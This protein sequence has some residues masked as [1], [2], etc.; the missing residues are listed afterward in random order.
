NILDSEQR[1]WQGASAKYR[2]LT[3]VLRKR[4][5]HLHEQFP[6]YESR[7]MIRYNDYTYIEDNGCIYQQKTGEQSCEVL[8]SPED[9]GLGEYQI[10]KIRVSTNQA[11]LAVT[12]KTFEIEE[13]TC[14]VIKLGS[15]PR[16]THRIQNVF[17]CEWVAESIL[18][19]TRQMNLQ[20]RQVYGMDFNQSNC[21]A[22]LVYNENDYRFFVDLYST[23][24]GRY[25]TINS[26]SKDTSEVWLLDKTS[27]WE[28]PVLVQGRVPGVTYFIEHRDG[29]LY[30]LSND[31]EDTEYKL[32]KAA[33][34]SDR[35]MWELVYVIKKRT[36]LVD[37]EMLK[38]HCIMF[39]KKGNQLYLEVICLFTELVI[40]SIKLPAWTCALEPDH[41]PENRGGSCR[42]GLSSPVQYPVPFVYSG[43]ENQLFV[44]GNHKAEMAQPYHSQRLEAKSKD[45]AVVPVTIFYKQNN[46]ELRTR[47][48]L[49]HVYGAYGMD[50]NMS[51]KM[52]KRMLVDDGWILGYC[53]VRGGGELG[54]DWHKEG[55]LDKK[56]NGLNDLHCCISHLHELG[57]SQP[58]YTAIEAASAG[59]VLAGA[60]Y[61]S[62]PNLFKAMVLEAPFLDVL[63]T[64][65]DISLPLTI[66]EMGEWG[67]PVS[68]KEY[69]RYIKTYCPY[70]N[71]GPKD[72]PSLLIT[73]YTNDQRVPLKGLLRY[74]AKLRK[75]L[76]EYRLKSKVPDDKIPSVYLDVRPG[77]SHCDSLS[78]EDSLQKVLL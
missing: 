22:K 51:F 72:Y 37:M 26:N 16:V 13:S 41:P 54:S 30:M 78:W 69:Y 23:R 57:Y 43:L 5:V 38:D 50:L 67:N 60:L 24:D 59:G 8:L 68:E 31:G 10:Q 61:N 36:K 64:M 74:I 11:F 48:L 47:P 32:L 2:D 34:S 71:I 33:L 15:V 20:C 62:S 28:P 46:K 52:E 63:N 39:L 40:Q 19:Y 21:T 18:L 25:L 55:I 17:T 73:A 3:L 35:E 56:H 14:I 53:H 6:S 49:V 7:E 76:I 12:L 27:P 44:D 66:E 42:F 58:R 45:G 4:L 75:A 9:V 65:M 1:R 70:Q 77:G 29:F